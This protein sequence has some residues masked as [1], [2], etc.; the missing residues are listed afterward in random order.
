MQAENNTGENMPPSGGPEPP[1]TK[2]TWLISGEEKR[3]DAQGVMV[4][5]LSGRVDLRVRIFETGLG[6]ASR[7]VNF[8]LRA[9]TDHSQVQ[10]LISQ[11]LQCK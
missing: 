1:D 8:D 11:R 2:K 10:S 6:K 4:Q 5:Q 7:I 3:V 9:K